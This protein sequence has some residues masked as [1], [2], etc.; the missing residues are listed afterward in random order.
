MLLHTETRRSLRGI[1]FERD[2]AIDVVFADMRRM[3]TEGSSDGG[4]SIW[5]ADISMKWNAFARWLERKDRGADCRPSVC[6]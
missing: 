3:P 5:Y 1:M 2:V 6:T 4:D